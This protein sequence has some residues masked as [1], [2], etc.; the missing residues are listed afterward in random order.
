MDLFES[1]RIE[2][3]AKITDQ[4]VREIVAFLNTDGGKIYIGISDDGKVIGTK[5]IDESLRIISDI[6]CSQIEPSPIELVK[7]D[8]HFLENQPVIVVNVDKGTESIYC[9]KKY[10]F[11]SVGCPIRVGSTCREMSQE[12]VQYR[13]KMRYSDDDLLVSSPTN[14]PELSFVTL[15]NYYSNIG[16]KLNDENFKNNLNLLNKKGQYNKLAELVSDNS[17]YSFIFVKFEGANKASL[18]QR[19]NYGNKSIL[20]AYEQM[21]NRIEAENICISDTTTRPRIDKF[22]Y[23]IESVDEAIINAIVHNDWSVGEPQ[24]AFF[25]NRIEIISH[26]GLPHNLTKE[27]YFAG[28]TKPRNAALMKIFS[29]LDI[30]DNTGHGIPTIIEHYGKDVFD[31]EPNH[32]IIS[33]PF[34]KDILERFKREHTDIINFDLNE[35]EKLILEQL[36]LDPTTT[37]QKIALKLKKSRRTIERYLKS[38]QA[39]D[40][41][42]RVGTIRNGYWK[43]IK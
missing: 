6:V 25:N 21:K 35:P 1:N 26:G 8:I 42:E 32:I 23:N 28:I 29:D 2:F 43:I 16:L 24:V 22:L 3:K 11:S 39:K 30:A 20:F 34:D 33:I 9:I 37:A 17:R 13:Y 18:S 5:N 31:I 19:S 41:I 4:L 40:Y 36:S 27:E 7:S 10:G 38:L 12:Q 14:L 15:K